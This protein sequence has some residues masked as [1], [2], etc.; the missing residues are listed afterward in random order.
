MGRSMGRS[1]TAKQRTNKDV[2]A[3][4]LKMRMT[5]TKLVA[6]EVGNNGRMRERHTE[7]WK[8]LA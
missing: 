3:I 7:R 6:D 5:L 8:Q 2:A 1:K 4:Q